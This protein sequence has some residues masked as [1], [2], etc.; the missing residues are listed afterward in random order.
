MRKVAEDAESVVDRDEHHAAARKSAA[1]IHRQVRCTRTQS[2]PMNPD[3]HWRPACIF[4][5]PDVKEQTILTHRANVIGIDASRSRRRL[6]ASCAELLR[7]A[8]T[9]PFR[10]GDRRL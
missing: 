10:Q 1:F 9:A 6:Y 2:T 3:E 4:R 8:D 7:I 5:R